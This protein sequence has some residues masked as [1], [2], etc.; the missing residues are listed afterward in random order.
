MDEELEQR[1]DNKYFSALWTIWSLL[2]LL[3]CRKQPEEICKQAGWP[4]VPR[5]GRRSC[6]PSPDFEQW[7][8]PYCPISK[9][10]DSS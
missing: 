4:D 5:G 2:L 6:V 9:H 7:V 3:Q 1:P 10:E 8:F